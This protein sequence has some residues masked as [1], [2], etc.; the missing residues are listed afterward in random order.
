MAEVAEFDA[1]NVPV[2]CDP[3]LGI[4]KLAVPLQIDVSLFWGEVVAY[5]VN[6]L[7]SFINEF[8]T[9]G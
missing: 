9:R 6:D 2:D 1:I 8:L 3:S 4:A 5:F 7:L